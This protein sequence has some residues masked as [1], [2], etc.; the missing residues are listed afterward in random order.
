MTYGLVKK[1]DGSTYVSTIFALKYAGRESAAIVFDDTFQQIKML[2]M[3]GTG[4]A[5]SQ[6]RLFV[7]ANDYAMASGTWAG[8]DWVLRDKKLWK[9][10]QSGQEVRTDRFPQFKKH[11]RRICLP[12]WF[13]VKTEKDISDLANVSMGFHDACICAYTETGRDVEVVFDTT[14]GCH[15]TV[16]FAGVTDADFKEKV[17][18]ILESE[19]RKT[20]EGFSFVVLDGFAGWTDGCYYN[21][22]IGE[23][24]IRCKRIFWQIR[25]D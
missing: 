17:G 23:P 12:D 21:V 1:Q 15:I 8:P 9:E 11:T 18:Q 2:D 3:W 4:S 6:R 20:E 22:P 19:I 14:W 7:L 25:V 5:G 16:R 24:Y 13:E 10:L